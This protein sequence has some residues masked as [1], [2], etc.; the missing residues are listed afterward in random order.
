MYG[1]CVM[2][3]ILCY[4]GYIINISQKNPDAKTNAGIQ[5]LLYNFLFVPNNLL[6]LCASAI[7]SLFYL[8][9][10]LLLS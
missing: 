10:P 3:Q 4:R 1:K 7:H 5:K 2:V 6:Q 8:I 9:I